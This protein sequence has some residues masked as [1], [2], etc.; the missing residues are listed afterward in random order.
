MICIMI[1]AVR[2]LGNFSDSLLGSLNIDT[3]ADVG[4]TPV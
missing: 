3:I 4:D 2:Q 1:A